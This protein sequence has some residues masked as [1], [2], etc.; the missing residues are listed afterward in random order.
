VFD[1][2]N[3]IY[4]MFPWFYARSGKDGFSLNNAFTVDGTTLNNDVSSWRSNFTRELI[5]RYRDTN[6]LTMYIIKYII[7]HNDPH[8]SVNVKCLQK[9]VELRSLKIH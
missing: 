1:K 8:K 9:Y 2:Y 7:E 3:H 6:P 4:K 5:T